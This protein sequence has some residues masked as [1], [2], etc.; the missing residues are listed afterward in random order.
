MIYNKGLSL[1]ESKLQASLVAQWLRTHLPMQETQVQ[2]LVQED[3][4]PQGATNPELHNYRACAL[5]PRS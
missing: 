3:P 5:Q 4:V 2:S 1:K